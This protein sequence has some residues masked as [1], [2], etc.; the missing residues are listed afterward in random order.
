MREHACVREAPPSSA[1][2]RDH[3]VEMRHL[4]PVRGRELAGTIDRIALD[5]RRLA[6]ATCGSVVKMGET[7]LSSG[8]HLPN[9]QAR[10]AITTSAHAHDSLV[11]MRSNA[12]APRVGV[13]L[14]RHHRAR[15][16]RSRCVAM[17]MQFAPLDPR[18]IHITLYPRGEPTRSRHGHHRAKGVAA[19]GFTFKFFS[20]SNI[21]PFWLAILRLRDFGVRE[22]HV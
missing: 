16:T 18:A 3:V 11:T 19:R 7:Y 4:L 9:G 17:V 12:I 14:S 20:D 5:A 21:L 6:R 15:C 10:R 8:A 1:G 22:Q 13:P 2:E